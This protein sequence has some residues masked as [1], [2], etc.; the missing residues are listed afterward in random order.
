MLHVPPANCRTSEVMP[1]VDV[2]YH[3][4]LGVLEKINIHKAA[5]PD[6]FAG[7]SFNVCQGHRFVFEV[8]ISAVS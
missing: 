5:R 2:N 3:G 8:H 1:P 7:P 4:V 6:A